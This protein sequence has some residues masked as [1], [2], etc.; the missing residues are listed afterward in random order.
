MTALTEYER[1]EAQALWRAG[2]D[3]QR[4]NVIVS[5]GDATLTISDPH[6]RALA[7]WSLPAVRRLNPG[8][9][10]AL[11]APSSQPDEAEELELEDAEMIRAI[12]KLRAAI[13][14]SRPRSGRLRLALS[15]LVLLA[16][17]TF[18][19]VWLPGA[20]ERQALRLLPD[21]TR[22]AVGERL[23]TRIHRVAGS[24]CGSPLG[25]AALARLGRRVLGPDSGA[26]LVVVSAGVP[27]SG[28]LPGGVI[29]LNRVL[30][31]NYEAP[32]VVAGFI[33]AESERAREADPMAALLDHAGTLATVKLLTTGTIADNV[34]DSYAE[35]MLTAPPQP[36]SDAALLAR[37]AAAHVPSSPYAYAVDQTGES[38]LGL[39]EAD[40]VPLSQAEPL[41]PDADWVSLQDICLQ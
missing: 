16:A 22:R 15:A 27:W 35:V 31:E 17:A 37:F 9:R 40:P 1:L 38:V 7:H 14:R 41:L 32:E 11:Y 25:R 33:L 36:L 18:A 39:I 29:L 6:D 20:L 8:K 21:V 4:Q 30:V 12:E 3:A 2:A 5:L 26:R 23:L 19:L 34:L 28:H 10:P 13:A 24:A